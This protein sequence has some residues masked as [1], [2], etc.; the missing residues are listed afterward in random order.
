VT[1]AGRAVWNTHG[2]LRRTGGMNHRGQ[3]LQT[4]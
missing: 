1:R 2:G 3:G 4:V